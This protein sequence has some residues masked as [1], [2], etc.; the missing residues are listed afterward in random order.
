MRRFR[1]VQLG[2]E[3]VSASEKVVYALVL[4]MFLLSVSPISVSSATVR[5]FLILISGAG[6]ALIPVWYQLNRAA[7]AA[8]VERRRRDW[9]ELHER[10]RSGAES[11]YHHLY[12]VSVNLVTTE[13]P[14]LC[15]RYL[16][17]PEELPWDPK[18]QLYSSNYFE[19][20]A[21]RR[22]LVIAEYAMRVDKLSRD[23]V[24][25][26]ET[27]YVATLEFRDDL[28]VELGMAEDRCNAAYDLASTLLVTQLAL[29][30]RIAVVQHGVEDAK[31]LHAR[32]LNLLTAEC[33]RL[34]KVGVDVPE[35]YRNPLQFKPPDFSRPGSAAVL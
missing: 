34:K 26:A 7:K 35:D 1:K 19:F 30:F 4:A 9:I 12:E 24:H 11:C 3:Y 22:R 20:L 27:A 32:T 8:E 16:L 5:E 28:D 31:K 18:D 10:I 6:L 29:D 33:A 2:L 21:R 13:L 25:E 15:R 14:D 23:F 17:D